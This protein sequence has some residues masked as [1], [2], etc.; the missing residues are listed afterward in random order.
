MSV[1]AIGSYESLLSGWK[2]E[3]RGE[4]LKAQQLFG[5]KV[6]RNCI[7]SVAVS[8]THLALGGTGEVI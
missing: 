5:F 3:Q 4:K 6:E 2:L 8:L 1:F 7:R